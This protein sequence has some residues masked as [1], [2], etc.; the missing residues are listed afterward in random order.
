MIKHKIYLKR[1]AIICILY[2]FFGLSLF[3]QDTVQLLPTGRSLPDVLPADEFVY[4]S[5]V[6]DPNITTSDTPAGAPAPELTP[7]QKSAGPDV[8][9]IHREEAIRQNEITQIPPNERVNVPPDSNGVY[10]SNNPKL[11]PGSAPE[12]ISEKPGEMPQPSQTVEGMPRGTDSAPSNEISMPPEQEIEPSSYPDPSS[13]A[14]V[15]PYSEVAVG[16]DGRVP[17]GMN[18]ANPP[19]AEAKVPPYGGVSI[20]PESSGSPSVSEPVAGSP[21]TPAPKTSEWRFT[22][23]PTTDRFAPPDGT[24]QVSPFLSQAEGTDTEEK[25]EPVQ[26]YKQPVAATT[27]QPQQELSRNVITVLNGRYIQ[28]GSYRNM[29]VAQ[30]SASSLTGKINDALLK[31]KVAVY[32]PAGSQYYKVV[33]GPFQMSEIGVNLYKIRKYGYA[34]AY[35]IK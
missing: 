26:E 11:S 32:K 35:T 19:Y 17:P 28:V 6:D 10:P 15:P 8:E 31:E 13:G 34:D 3:A 5:P 23:N 12:K 7:T 9:N 21:P 2:V 20:E 22:L 18:P 29:N 14:N 27:P 25:K 24:E 16:P 33:V 30:K 4:V 1:I